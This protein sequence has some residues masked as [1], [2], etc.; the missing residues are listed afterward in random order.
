MAIDI[1]ALE[2]ENVQLRSDCEWADVQR[3]QN[4]DWAKT[5]EDRAAAAEAREA[6]LI[7]QRAA[8]VEA[9]Q[10]AFIQEVGLKLAMDV[11]RNGWN[12]PDSAPERVSIAAERL[13]AALQLA[14][15]E[16]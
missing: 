3:Q 9:A 13:R 8:L 15:V 14:G 10:L 5:A 12:W 7:A 1:E 6:E 2:A 4:L 11:Q 16:M